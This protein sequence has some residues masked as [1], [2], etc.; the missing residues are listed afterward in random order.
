MS[1]NSEYPEASFSPNSTY[2]LC[3][4]LAQ[5]PRSQ[6]LVIFVSTMKI[7]IMMIQP[8]TLPLNAHARGV[9]MY[10]KCPPSG[11][12]P[13]VFPPPQAYHT[14]L[15]AV[16]II[17]LLA[18]SDIM[19]DQAKLWSDITKSWADIHSACIHAVYAGIPLERNP[20]AWLLLSIILC[21]VH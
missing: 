18:W 9:I 20:N 17:I 16:C 6:D 12:F 14:W 11:H 1:L 10:Q 7:T 3:L 13:L 15:C 21:R 5:V 8:I 4:Q 2:W 19:S